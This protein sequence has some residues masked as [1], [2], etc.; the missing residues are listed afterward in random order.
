MES[1]ALQQEELEALAWESR[2]GPMDIDTFQSFHI[3]S[4]A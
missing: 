4:Q 1:E 3:S 2:T